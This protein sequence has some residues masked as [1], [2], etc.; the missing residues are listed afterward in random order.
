MKKRGVALQNGAGGELQLLPRGALLA[1]G[2]TQLVVLQD[3][4]VGAEVLVLKALGKADPSHGS[5]YIII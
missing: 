5:I 4:A 3:E 2:I 1:Q